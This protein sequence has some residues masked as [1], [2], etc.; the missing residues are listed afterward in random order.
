MKTKKLLLIGLIITMLCGCVNIENLSYEE[1]LTGFSIDA[2]QV[3]SHRKGFSFYVPKS[4]KID[5]AVTNYII[6]ASEKIN[7]YLYIDMVSYLKKNTI[8]YKINQDASYSKKIA[9]ADKQGYIEVILQENNKYLI[10][11][12]YNYAKI[13]VM[14]EKSFINEA[15]INSISILNIIKYND[16]VIEN[17]LNDDDLNYTEESFNIFEKKKN[18]SNVL[19]YGDVEEG[20]TNDSDKI[21]DS[22]FI[23]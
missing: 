11:I 23:N 4:L 12:M 16:K 5:E 3:N 8:N 1:I 13:E 17:L 6:F 15:L 18:N 9:H 14:V 22:D 21:I 2:K 10:E 7:Y 19:D 20:S